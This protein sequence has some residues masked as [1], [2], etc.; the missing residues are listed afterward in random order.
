MIRYH[1]AKGYINSSPI[2]FRVICRKIDQAI[3]LAQKER[4]DKYISDNLSDT[5]Y[6]EKTSFIGMFNQVL[7]CNHDYQVLNSYLTT[8]LFP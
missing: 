8:L 6:I 3:D 7:D 1:H 4:I 2:Q 5:K